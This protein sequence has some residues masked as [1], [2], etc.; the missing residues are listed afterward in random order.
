MD[1]R[2]QREVLD[3]GEEVYGKVASNS[4][5]S[6]AIAAGSSQLK[7]VAMSIKPSPLGWCVLACFA[8]WAGTSLLISLTS[9]AN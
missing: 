9:A 7:D 2:H 5:R 8:F 6:S 1:W 3:A 4:P